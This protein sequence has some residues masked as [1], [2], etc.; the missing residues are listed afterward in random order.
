MNEKLA[1]RRFVES[2]MFGTGRVR[3]FTQDSPVL[4]DVWLAYANALEDDTYTANADGAVHLLL[5]PFRDKQA[6]DVRNKLLERLKM[7]PLP[8]VIYNQSTVGA[9]LRFEELVRVV[10]PLT[11][12][13][14]RLMRRFDA[15]LLQDPPT[16]KLLARA[17]R[18]PEDPRA[19]LGRV[20]GAEDIA[21]L[22]P[23]A[24]WLI[25]VVGA[26][27]IYFETKTLP[28]LFEEGHDDIWL[29]VVRAV[30][31]LLKGVETTPA[32][33]VYVA[34]LNRAAWP[35]ISRSSLAIKADAARQLFNISCRDIR[36]A[37]VDSGIDARHPAFRK[38]G[39]DG[40]LAAKAFAKKD[41]RWTNFTRIVATYDFS[42]IDKLLDPNTADLPARLEALAKR[43]SAEAA[44]VKEQIASLNASLQAG[45][46]ID[47]SLI[48]P[49][50]RIP[51]DDRYA[52]S[53]PENDHGTHVAGILAGDWK[54]S[55]REDLDGDYV[56]VCPDLN[57][58][59][60]RV[61]SRTGRGNEFTVMAAMQFVRWLN[62]THDYFEIHGANLSLSIPH[63]VSNY[64][65]G[66]TPVCEEAER[67]VAGGVVVV[68]AAGNQGYRRYATPEGAAAEAYN[69]ISIV[70]PGNADSVITVGATHRFRP[71]TYG[72]SYFSS[73]GPTGD[74]RI[75]PDL[76][77][78]GE[79]IAA[80]ILND[81]TGVKDGTSM[82]A[83]H[84]SGAAALLM[85]RH[86]ELV[87]RPARVKQVLCETATDLG[88][89]RYF[90]GNGMLDVLRALQAV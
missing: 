76:V 65:C 55:D 1:R 29:D 49:L 89:E 8:R 60:L 88:R 59:D 31:K 18:N 23:D 27:A 77:A 90:Q 53:A 7:K 30:A 73:R 52:N 22:P 32:A 64:A 40:K 38:R 67:L 66:R 11:G 62:A 5:A 35:T 19:E 28:P 61:L 15:A 44:R 6:G 33:Y 80:P 68:A 17:I 2:L 25:R 13:W 10:I 42:E 46:S 85:A 87:G 39:E 45:R 47:W 74:G 24:L 12:W 75:K 63:D 50:I 78:P 34:S 3:R 84:V 21:K 56:G 37:V 16:Q 51:H 58:Y 36:W 82:A 83:P 14:E 70:D 69:T 81:T 71:H 9:E 48:A 20:K 72:V 43:N 41:G 57:I 86:Q 54:K 26:L 4:P 79:K